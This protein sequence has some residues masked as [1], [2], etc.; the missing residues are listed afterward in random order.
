MFSAGSIWRLYV[1]S[2]VITLVSLPPVELAEV[3]RHALSRR[4]KKN[5]KPPPAPLKLGDP[6]KDIR[7]GDS[8]NTVPGLPKDKDGKEQVACRAYGGLG[9]YCL[10]E[11]C[12]Y[13]SLKDSDVPKGYSLSDWRFDKCTRYPLKDEKVPGTNQAQPPALAFKVSPIGIWAHNIAG[14]MVLTGWDEDQA[15]FDKLTRV[16]TCA[17]EKV[18]DINNQ[19]PVCRTCTRTDFKEGDEPQIPAP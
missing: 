19:R 17:W 5:D 14:K 4:A 9:Y 2:A 7:C 11:T 10:L 3:E 1:L 16:Y 15:H 12:K 18:A 13:G 8:W 6:A